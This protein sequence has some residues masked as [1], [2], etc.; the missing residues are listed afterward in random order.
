MSPVDWSKTCIACQYCCTYVSLEIDAPK[1]ETDYDVI[2]WYL[3]HKNI[4]IYIDD[5]D[6]W[7]FLV[8]AVCENLGPAGCAIYE[9]RFQIC[10]N[11]KAS[12]C[13]KSLGV[14]SE[15]VLFR[16]VQD[17][18]RWLEYRRRKKDARRKVVPGTDRTIRGHLRTPSSRKRVT[19]S[20]A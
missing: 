7:Y 9:D 1:T 16:T 17:F 15:K 2:R 8:D 13:E 3:A 12:E 20:Q 5:D 14:S 4:N 10:R 11:Y 19:V 6:L 18:D